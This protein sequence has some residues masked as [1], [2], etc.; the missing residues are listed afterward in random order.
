MGGVMPILQVER[1]RPKEDVESR[2][3]SWQNYAE[4]G[5]FLIWASWSEP[6]CRLQVFSVLA[7][8]AAQGKPERPPSPPGQLSQQRAIF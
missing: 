3:D 6:V 2:A 1:L 5:I 8:T 4:D 7:L